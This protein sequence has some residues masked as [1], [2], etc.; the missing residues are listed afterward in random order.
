MLLNTLPGDLSW[1]VCTWPRVQRPVSL[2]R[3]DSWSD[4][5]TSPPR[6]TRR[7]RPGHEERNEAGDPSDQVR[8]RVHL[9]RLLAYPDGN[10]DAPGGDG[11]WTE[12]SRREHTGRGVGVGWEWGPER[13]LKWV[14][15]A[16]YNYDDYKMAGQVR[17]DRVLV[18]ARVKEKMADKREWNKAMCSNM[19]GPGDY[20]TKW[21]KSDRERQIS[22]AITYM[23]NLKKR[24]K[25][26]DLQIRNRLTDIGNKL[27]V[28]KGEKGGRDKLGVCN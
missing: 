19:N 28:T 2:T 6:F 20:H 3:A 26:T 16:E 12:S 23:W 8:A 1:H 18:S 10:G 9:D 13:R 11:G 7:T 25:W 14:A 17:A 4:N 5:S 27:M 15:S 21:S 22:H 24:Y